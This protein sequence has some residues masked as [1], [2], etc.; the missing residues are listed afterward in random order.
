MKSA[1]ERWAKLAADESSWTDVARYLP[2]LLEYQFTGNV[3]FMS[4]AL[5]R[6]MVLLKDELPFLQKPKAADSEEFSLSFLSAPG[7][8]GPARVPRRLVKC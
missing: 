1:R 7:S 2:L 6:G 4:A 3:R 8:A 5:E